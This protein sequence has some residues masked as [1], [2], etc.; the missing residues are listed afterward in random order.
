VG[1]IHMEVRYRS[2]QNR[3]ISFELKF[4]IEVQNFRSFR[5]FSDRDHKVNEKFLSNFSLDDRKH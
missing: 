4:L 1:Q 3:K 5:N 2:F